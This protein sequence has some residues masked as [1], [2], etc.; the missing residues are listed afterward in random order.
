MQTG[1]NTVPH[2]SVTEC[3]E[4]TSVGSNL[5]IASDPDAH[6]IVH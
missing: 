3:G 5:L 1:C 6:S 2:L 4:L